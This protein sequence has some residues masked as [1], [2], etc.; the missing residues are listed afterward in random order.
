MTDT[1]P[2]HDPH[3]RPPAE[4]GSFVLQVD[5]GCPHNRCSFCGMYRRTAFRSRP[6]EEVAGIVRLEAPSIPLTRRVFLA[7]GDVMHRPYEQLKAVLEMLR[8]AF[9]KLARVSTYANGRSVL[10][11]SPRELAELKAL[12]L[13]TLYLGLESGHEGLLRAMNKPDT[14]GEMVRA[15]AAAH[16]AGM[17]M[18]VMVLLG[19]GGAAGSADHADATASAVNLIQPKF[20]S[21]L[22][23]IPVPGTPL[24]REFHEG[25]FA[26]LSPREALAEMARLISGLR[27]KS[28]VF[29]A[30]HASNVV[31]LEARLPR[32]RRALLD[33]LGR[34]S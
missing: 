32:D 20:L 12:G 22:R 28:T 13:H 4:A 11:K 2:P 10:A 34:M 26:P 33:S 3:Y 9:P 16:E 25:R 1:P 6:I 23:V 24:F 21:V 5:S 31:P 19:L 18:S 29:R 15:C 27:L 30:D 14:V 8:G 17:R 7:D